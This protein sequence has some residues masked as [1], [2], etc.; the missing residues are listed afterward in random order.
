M[1]LENDTEGNCTWWSPIKLIKLAAGTLCNPLCYLLNRWTWCEIRMWCYTGVLPFG[2]SLGCH[3]SYV[4]RL[5]DQACLSRDLDVKSK[6]FFKVAGFHQA[7]DVQV[8]ETGFGWFDIGG[9]SI[10]LCSEPTIGHIDT[11]SLSKRVYLKMER[12]SVTVN[13]LTPSQD[14]LT[15]S[16]S[17]SRYV[18]EDRQMVLPSLA[19]S[20][21]GPGVPWSYAMCLGQHFPGE[22]DTTASSSQLW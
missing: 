16:P 2:T 3:L 22:A 9:H 19:S 1:L 8:G 21:K 20:L 17:W 5:G 15:W 4:K 11:V 14:I 12:G 18:L 13:L 6:L 7:F 10:L